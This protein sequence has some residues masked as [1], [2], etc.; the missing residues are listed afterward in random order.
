MLPADPGLFGVIT[1]QGDLEGVFCFKFF[2]V[3][4]FVVRWLGVELGVVAQ[5]AR[6]VP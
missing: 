3:G 1:E 2:E 5:V 4:F 6:S